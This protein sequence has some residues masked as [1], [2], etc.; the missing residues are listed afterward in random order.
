MLEAVRPMGGEKWRL[1]GIA[2]MPLGRQPKSD[3]QAEWPQERI[4][5]TGTPIGDYGK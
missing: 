5:Q 2:S 1:V 3:S 4:G